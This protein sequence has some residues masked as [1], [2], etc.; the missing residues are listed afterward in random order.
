[1]CFMIFIYR[2]ELKS[3]KTDVSGIVLDFVLYSVIDSLV[4]IFKKG[5]KLWSFRFCF[6]DISTVYVNQVCSIQHVH[7]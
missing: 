5:K 3:V 7:L 6:I 1:M 2:F 4:Y